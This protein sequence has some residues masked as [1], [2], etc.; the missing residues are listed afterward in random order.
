MSL[1][2]RD[3]DVCLFGGVFVCLFE[4]WAISANGA[5]QPESRGTG[6]KCLFAP[7]IQTWVCLFVCWLCVCLFDWNL[8]YI[9]WWSCAA[10]ESVEWQEPNVSLLWNSDVS[11]SLC[12]LVVCLF[13]CLK[14]EL[15]QLVELCSQRA[16]G[17]GPNVSVLPGFRRKF[18]SLFV[19][20][21]CVCLFVWNLSY[22]SWWSCA[23]REPRDRSQCLPA[24]GIQTWICVF[25]CLFVC[26]QWKLDIKRSDITKYWYNKLFSLVPMN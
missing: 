24:P 17:Q 2:S 20:Y 18:V 21:K 26:L 25:A 15:H 1:C 14:S 23:A 4:I 19:G 22:I 7:G 11:L 12:L 13:V 6:A 10:S 3:S 5:V 9:S 8:S 16:E